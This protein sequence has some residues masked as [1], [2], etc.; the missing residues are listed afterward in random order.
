MG[1]YDPAEALP[2]QS[3]DYDE[4]M[5]G[6][7]SDLTVKPEFAQADLELRAGLLQVPKDQLPTLDKVY[8][9]SLVRSVNA[10]L[11]ASRWK[12]TP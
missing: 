12:P 2:A 10:E 11:D 1:K 9:F 3:I 7:T 6:R 8:D 4:F 5:H